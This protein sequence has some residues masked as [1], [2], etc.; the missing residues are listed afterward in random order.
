[1][2]Y[3][4]ERE[5]LRIPSTK[6][7]GIVGRKRTFDLNND[8]KQSEEEKLRVKRYIEDVVR[9]LNQNGWIARTPEGKAGLPGF[10]E[11]H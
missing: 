1:V 3:L 5:A 6:N 8:T 10:V 9:E 7:F 11:S 4:P 2:G